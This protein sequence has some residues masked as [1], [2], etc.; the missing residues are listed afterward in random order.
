MVQPWLPETCL[1]SL[2]A[3][4]PM[5]RVIDGWASEWFRNDPWQVLGGWDEVPHTDAGQFALIRRAGSME[6]RGGSE[7]QTT[8]AL[9][10]LGAGDQPPANA[11]DLAVLR[12]LGGRVLDDLEMRIKELGDGL[13]AARP[14]TPTQGFPR[15][16][17]ILIG[18][19]GQ[20]RLAIECRAA[21]LVQMAR[22]TFPTSHVDAPLANR[23]SV[24]DTIS[25]SVAVSLGTASISLKDLGDLEVGDL[26]L[27]DS[28]PDAPTRLMVEG[29]KSALAFS[30]S[31]AGNSC[32]LEYLGNQ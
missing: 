26:L 29:R 17:S 1:T 10:I 18:T 5:A 12:Q 9:A 30:I 4:Q 25:V 31:E 7:V 11:N 22:G 3:A 27:L 32:I 20:A 6:I 8:L 14:A 15:V 19:L 16:F 23:I 21:D 2:R 24:R 28:K 13:G